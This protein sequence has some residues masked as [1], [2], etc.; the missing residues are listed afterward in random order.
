M[1]PDKSIHPLIQDL[2]HALAPHYQTAVRQTFADYDFQ[3][4]DWFLSYVT[5]GMGANGITVS[6]FHH[7]YPYANKTQQQTFFEKAVEDGFLQTEDDEVFT[8][9]ELGN[10]GVQAFFSNARQALNTLTPMAESELNRL[11]DLLKRVVAATKAAPEPVEKFNFLISRSTTPDDSETAVPRIDQY[12][13]D[14]TVYRDD[15]HLATWRPL[16][17][18]GQAWEALTYVWQGDAH[19][20]EALAE[21]LPN[22]GYDAD[23]YETALQDLAARGWLT[24]KD[25]SYQ[26]TAAGQKLRDDAEE[27]TERNYLVGWSA[28]SDVEA[29]A[30]KN[31]LTQ[32]RDNLNEMTVEKTTAVFSDLGSVSGNVSGAMYTLT[33]PSVSPLIENAGIEKPGHANLLLLASVFKEPVTAKI[34]RQRSP[35]SALSRYQEGFAVLKDMGLIT[36]DENGYTLTENGRSLVNNILEA[37]HAHLAAIQPTL[38]DNMPLD[39]WNRLAELLERLDRSLLNAGDPPGTWCID[40]VQGL[41]MPDEPVALDRIDKV[42]DDINAF[43]DD[44]HIAAFKPY[45]V[46]GHTWEL[47]TDLWREEVTNPAEM[48]EK[49]EGRGYAEA[50]YQQALLDLLKRGWVE[51]AEAGKYVVTENGRFI[52]EEAEAQTDAYFYLPWGRLLPDSEELHTLLNQAESALQKAVEAAKE[53]VPV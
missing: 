41:P 3:G 46:K 34:M 21:S 9:T 12:I 17:I 13:T 42:L 52:R 37:F 11:A 33:R 4:S 22:R 14:I 19:T 7:I 35:Y 53:V 45:K 10:E 40:H 5:H 8:L 6:N 44:A 39:D 36:G 47:F 38:I 29:V 16:G 26:M 28:L 18:T 2:M 48:A 31:L 51:E 49:H 1:S 15:A 30:L 43:R 24:K 32:F 27:E 25:G 50:D 23:S 20:A